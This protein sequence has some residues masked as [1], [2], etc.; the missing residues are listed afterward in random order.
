M[1][2]RFRYVVASM[3]LA[4]MVVPCAAQDSQAPPDT[5]P[6]NTVPQARDPKPCSDDQRL[7]AGRD[8][9]HPT[10]P[11]NQTLSEKLEQTD[12]VLCPPNVDS[13]IEA[14]TPQAGP[15]PVIP[16]P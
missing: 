2:D 16:P 12:G 14:P 1:L 5:A 3:L 11:G 10:D 13:H 9:P 6:Q 7:R 15:M 8:D 4:G